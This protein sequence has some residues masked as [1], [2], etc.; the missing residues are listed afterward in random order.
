MRG[1]SG[2]SLPPK[3][4]ERGEGSLPPVSRGYTARPGGGP[5]VPRTD[6][7]GGIKSRSGYDRAGLGRFGRR[8]G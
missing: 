2:A 5:T 4:A 3:A 7:P 1:R 8:G 6:R